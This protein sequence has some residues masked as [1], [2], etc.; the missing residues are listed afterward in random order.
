M[1]LYKFFEYAYIA[2]AVWF[3][4]EAISIWATDRGRSYMLLAFAAVAGLT[5]R[6]LKDTL[7]GARPC[8]FDPWTAR[9]FE[10]W[11]GRLDTADAKIDCL[12]TAEQ[13]LLDTSAIES[14]HASIRR[15]IVMAS[16]QTHTQH[17]REASADF[18][19]HHIGKE[20][21]AAKHCRQAPP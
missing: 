21:A 8:T 13:V 6:S 18:V 5:E 12:T 14:A 9:F 1:K 2:I 20:V 11:R 7:E 10:H 16:T 19:L 3:I 4:G 17:L 15:R